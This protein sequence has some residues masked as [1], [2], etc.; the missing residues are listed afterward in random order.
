VTRE[1][2]EA[3]KAKGQ[4]RPMPDPTAL[5]AGPKPEREQELLAKWKAATS[6]APAART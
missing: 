2:E 6:A 3:A 1:L 5:R 4:P